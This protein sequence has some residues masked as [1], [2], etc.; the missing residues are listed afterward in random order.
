MTR[1]P[2]MALSKIGIWLPESFELRGEFG[3][4]FKI[5][6]IFLRILCNLKD[7]S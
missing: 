6:V 5:L 4:G 1:E 2:Y 7:Y 3:T